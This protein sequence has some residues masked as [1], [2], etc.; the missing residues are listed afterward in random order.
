MHTLD[1]AEY[2]VSQSL[3]RET[4]FNWCV[5]FVLKKRA[6]IISL[7]KQRSVRYLKCN[8]KYG[9]KLPKMVEEAKILDKANGNTLWSDAIAKEMT[10]V[11]V[12]F[13]ILDD[14]EYVLRNYQSV[15]CHMIFNVKMENFIQ[16]ARLVALVHT[17]K[18][19]A[20]VTYAR[21]VSR[22]TFRIALT[23]AALN[24]LQVKQ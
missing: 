18:A 23:T 21:V 1:T 12:A 13:K 7:V 20:A 24:D 11:K 19:P 3:E 17:T 9:I 22:E 5:P 14:D 6:R 16:K 10:N 2:A 15:K 8:E 4:A